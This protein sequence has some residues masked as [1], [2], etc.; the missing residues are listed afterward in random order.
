MPPKGKRSPLRSLF[1]VFM[2][3]VGAGKSTAIASLSHV[4]NSLGFKVHKSFLKTFHGAAYILWWFIATLLYN[5]KGRVAPWYIVG[6][7][8]HRIAKVLILVSLY[9]D[10]FINIPLK[11]LFIL[12]LKFL[13]YII[14]C[15]EYVYSTLFDYLYS[16][17]RHHTKLR[18]YTLFPLKIIYVFGAAYRPNFIVFLDADTNIL[19]RRWSERGYGD[20]Q[21][22]YVKAQRR[23]LKSLIAT[24]HGRIMYIN[25]NAMKADETIRVILHKLVQ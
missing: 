11:V 23:F 14:L 15:E 22:I 3:P 2:G 21:P 4:L 19:L 17:V 20:P 9:I 1:I 16:F 10:A 7:L 8:N 24:S 6:K 5:M 18:L 25:T 12:T 13:G